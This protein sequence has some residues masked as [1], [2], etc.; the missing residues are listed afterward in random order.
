VCTHALP[1]NAL[2]AITC[3]IAAFCFSMALTAND[4]LK[5][6]G[7][8]KNRHPSVRM[9]V[10]LS[11]GGNEASEAAVEAALKW[12]AKHRAADGSWS[13]D[14]T[15][16]D[17][18]A[19]C[20]NPGK[21]DAKFA[22]TGL[23]L[24]TFLGRGETHQRGDYQQA[25]KDG[26]DY[27]RRNMTV[28]ANGGNMTAG[29][30]SMYG[31]AM[32][33]A[34]LAE[35][36]AMTQDKALV[37][38]AQAALNFIMYAQDPAG[39]GWR[40]APRQPGDTSVTGWQITAIQSAYLGNLSIGMPTIPGA[41]KFLDS[42]QA[43]GGAAYGYIKSGSTPATSAEGLLCRIWMGWE[44]SR[45]E[46]RRG[47]ERLA[48][49]G[50]QKGNL[51]FTYHA[52][53]LLHQFD[54]PAGDLWK[55]WNAEV[56]DYLLNEQSKT[57]HE[58]GS[59][60]FEGGDH[61]YEAGGRLYCT[62]LAAMTLE[63]Y[64]RYALTY[65]A[66]DR[67]AAPKTDKQPVT[68]RYHGV[69]VRDEYRWL[70]ESGD[71]K[72]QEWSA[73]QN[74]HARKYL[75]RLPQV[76]A[77]RKRLTELETGASGQHT[78]L[79]RQGERLFALKRQPPK[80]QPF[81]VWLANADEPAGEHVVIDPNQLDPAGHTSIDWFVPSPDGELVAVSLSEGGS[82]SGTV[83]VYQADDGQER[84][85]D[86]IPRVNGG[87]AG[88][89][90]AWGPDNAGFFYTRYP[91]TGERPPEDLDFY[92]QVYF[93]QL[94][95]STDDDRYEIGRDFP[96]I[97]EIEL[98]SSADGRWLL[99]S[100]QKGDGGE[101]AHY[102]RR[103][104]AGWT[105]VTRF[106]D[107]VVEAALGPDEALYLISRND[108]PRG[109]ILRLPM[110]S[111]K[112]SEAECIVPESPSENPVTIVSHFGL[113]PSFVV[114]PGLLYVLDQVGGPNEVRVFDHAGRLRGKLPLP[115]LASVGGI[116]QAE[117]D[118][119][120]FQVQTF[121]SPPAWYRYSSKSGKAEKTALYQTSP[122]QYEG[123]EVVRETATSKDGTSVPVSILRRKGTK[124]DGR[125]PTIL[126]G[127]GGY[128]ISLGPRF[129]PTRQLWLEQG[130]VFA[131][132]N[133]RGG[134]EFGEAWHRAGNLTNKQN[135]FDDFYAVAK[136][137]IDAGY[138]SSER[139]AM[140][141]GSNGGL[142]MGATFTQHPELCRAVVSHV[143]IYDM[144]RVE[145][146]PNGAFNVTEFG[147]VA[148][149]RQF[150]ALYAYSPYH[151]VKDS[152][153][154]PAVLFLTGA[155]DPRVDPMQSRKMTARL[156]AASPGSKTLLRTNAEA[157][158]G[159]GS[160]LAQR[161]E[162]GVDVY[163]FLFHELDV[164][165]QPVTPN[166]SQQSGRRPGWP[167]EAEL[168]DLTH[169]FDEQ[170][171]YWPT[172]NGF[173]LQKGPAGMTPKGYY[174]AANRFTCAE[175]GGTHIDA[176][177]HF[178]EGRRTV[179]EIPLRQLMG[180]A[181]VIDVSAE[182]ADNADY[183]I[184]IADLRRWEE[185]HHRQLVDVIVLL[186]TGFGRRW[187]NRKEYLGTD[188]TEPEAVANLHFPG[189]SPEAA[190]WLVE[191]RQVKAIGIDTASIDYGQSK[192]FG[193]HVKLFEHNVP[194]FE[195]VANLERLPE[196]GFT[197]IA[198][199]MKITGGTGAPLRVVAVVPRRERR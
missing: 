13:F 159:I 166:V 173:Q 115:D 84:E 194:A 162:E 151:H 154:Y 60:M 42:V 119:A 45:P 130:G 102:V 24:L 75:D 25:V 43:D 22:A 190:Q 196:E 165:Y 179:D 33:T 4:S 116:L 199:P 38:P 113:Q 73:A 169:P 20:G 46:L 98:Q 171:I 65:E 34:A 68:D 54:A 66:D 27:L 83:H 193:S 51:Y 64:Y 177:T 2:K 72:V 156:Q 122:A 186:R 26:L 97:A 123:C 111:L 95:S 112:L 48:A 23:A 155:N 37:A 74:A 125:N 58:I 61:G 30:G 181:V 40:Y 76:E 148:D 87:T 41:I 67:S 150:E 5:A 191:R 16:G 163:S 70:E 138:T 121:I 187:P 11:Q 135:V 91:R 184:G 157:G 92:M 36:Y 52:T 35:A 127:Y 141:G 69:E 124:L 93:H 101:F 142:L 1:K 15:G 55:A 31:Q 39:G 7:N 192:R 133:L 14:H 94:G 170:T 77:I 180:E 164:A 32:A 143:G 197:V 189:L 47:V 88:G 160:S 172:E 195:N 19:Q 107:R 126:T 28:S 109:K 145:L 174:Y 158:H 80:Q 149:K 82:E 183:K 29:G 182:C 178:Y 44:H 89:S 161:I 56:R 153:E 8:L 96:R 85:V 188:E 114:T 104:Q 146:S 71:P 128:G 99:A 118:D 63:V 175:H 131:I 86:R 90:L 49:I 17:C 108:A 59:W 12:L 21:L 105:Q 10:A 134:G 167:D 140:M 57:G 147:T 137:M 6:G 139:L 144:L 106:E 152:T 79:V 136:H 18:Q 168:V 62:A 9:K 78:N 50:P 81:L 3:A 117:G 103:P 185:K 132:A 176:P 120:L 110:K 100:V 53:E 129:S 198:L